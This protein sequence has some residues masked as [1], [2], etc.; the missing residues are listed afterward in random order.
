[1]AVADSESNI[2]NILDWTEVNL[3]DINL[4]LNIS[5]NDHTEYFVS[6]KAEN[7]AADNNDIITQSFTT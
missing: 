6:L 2:T 1:M 7:S 3:N 4:N 5:L